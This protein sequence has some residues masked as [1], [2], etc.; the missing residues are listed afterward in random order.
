M[1]LSACSQSGEIDPVLKPSVNMAA[2]IL[3]RHGLYLSDDISF[4][5]D[6]E[7][8]HTGLRPSGKF[9]AA[10]CVVR[11][12]NKNPMKKER[13]IYLNN[14]V[15]SNIGNDGYNYADNK[16]LAVLIHEIGHCQFGLPH[17][18]L[19][20]DMDN[21]KRVIDWTVDDSRFH[22]MNSKIGRVPP[23]EEYYNKLFGPFKNSKIRDFVGVIPDKFHFK[24][25]VKFSCTLD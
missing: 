12:K 10:V 4:F 23:T 17:I 14:I 24:K 16:L 7:N 13:E 18:G 3:E 15:L 1:T 2:E 20:Y 19:G 5:V 11:N 22:I 8:K 9:L 21:K 25:N 6:E